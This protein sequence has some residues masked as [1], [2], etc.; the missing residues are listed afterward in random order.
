MIASGSVHSNKALKVLLQKNNWK[1]E[2]QAGIHANVE[3][4]SNK[5]VR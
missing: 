1:T 4:E 3:K 5:I 2:Q